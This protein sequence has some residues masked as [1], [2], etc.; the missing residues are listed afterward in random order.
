MSPTQLYASPAFHLNDDTCV[1]VKASGET[2]VLGQLGALWM[3]DLHL[4]PEQTIAVAEAMT[5]A[6]TACI[7]ARGGA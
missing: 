7:A 4:T 2:V 5:E 3:H 6:A 1:D